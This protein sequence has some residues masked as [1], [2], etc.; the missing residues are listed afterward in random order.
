MKSTPFAKL[1]LS[2]LL[3]ACVLL[4]SGPV[5]TL[6]S[7]AAEGKAQVGT[8]S[9]D[10]SRDALVIPV[11]GSAPAVQVRKLSARQYLAV[12]TGCELSRDE[13]QGQRLSSAVLAGWS[14]A[15]APTGD[16]LLLRLTLTQ[17]ATPSFQFSQSAQG[18][19][20]SFH[21]ALAE[22]NLPAVAPRPAKTVPVAAQPTQG[23]K[24]GVVGRVVAMIGS[25]WSHPAQPQQAK[26][27]ATRRAPQ[28]AV[29]RPVA[30][31]AKPATVTP[32]A[33]PVAAKPVVQHVAAKAEPQHLAVAP[34]AAHDVAVF[35]TPRYGARSHLLVLPFS[36]RLTRQSLAPIHLNS[37][38]AYLDVAGSRPAFGGVR[39]GSPQAPAF[40][41][42]VA[43]KRPNRE[44]TRF[45]FAVTAP[46]DIDVKETRGALLIAVRPKAMLLGHA[47]TARPAVVAT[48]RAP[49]QLAGRSLVSRPF[50]DEARYGLVVPYIGQTPVYRWQK[51]G[52]REAVV[53][54]KGNLNAVGE[55]V[56]RF[57]RHRVMSSWRLTPSG[58]PGVV[59]LALTFN[60]SAELVV[61]AD[62]TR[63]Q[64]LLIPQPRLAGD[65]RDA[66]AAGA[67]TVLAGVQRDGASRYIYIPFSGEAPSYTVEQVSPT[68]AYVNFNETRIPGQNV[69]FYAP[70]YHPSLNYWLLSNRPEAGDVRLALSLTQA[71]APRVY[72]DHANHRL[73]VVLDDSNALGLE[74]R[75]S[76]PMAPA[77][78][79]NAK[80]S[81]E[82]PDAAPTVDAA[83]RAS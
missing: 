51:Q 13:L 74:P 59:N 11:R 19:V 43:A 10:R 35:G 72:E 27:P 31:A 73:V 70:N 75:R 60:R 83:R 8:V 6:A 18:I 29:S 55:L 21:G 7:F 81:A 76:A 78:W 58:E 44:A 69:T 24:K 25:L 26:A 14:L 41:R 57:Q 62:P 48:H 23:E 12:L 77:P 36:G 42:W 49:I 63:R 65:A 56:Q 80:P 46:A 3:G 38:W 67:K 64:L 32:K 40:D 66:A 30:V 37:R 34:Q 22:R 33:H 2:S 5:A 28:H 82:R 17:D 54:I 61:A 47:P 16:K 15:E 52:D 71:A 68:F 53:A 1:G 50:F 45:S 79:E 20:V 9:F 4:A 39:F